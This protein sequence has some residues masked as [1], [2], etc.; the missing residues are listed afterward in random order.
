MTHDDHQS[1][2]ADAAPPE[3]EA[4][5]IAREKSMVWTR[6]FYGRDV[7]DRIIETIDT[8]HVLQEN[9]LIRYLLRAVMAGVLVALMYAFAYQ[10]KTD[11]GADF[12]HGLSL[13]IT[14]ISFSVALALIYFTNSELLTSNFM[15]FTVGL[16]YRKVRVSE[17]LAVLGPCLL[18]NLLGILV[19]VLLIW[20]ADM[21]S[22]AFVDNVVHTVQAKTVESSAWTIFVKAIFANY[23]I[24]ISVI[25]AMQVRES[26]AKIVVFVIGVTVFAYMGYEHVIA[27]SALFVMALFFE[28]ESVSTLHIG[29]NFICSLL[30]N[31][32]GG[33]LVVGLFY[34]YLNDDRDSNRAAP[35]LRSVSG[36]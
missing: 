27:N 22:Q 13:Y 15:Y 24:N 3:T 23:F 12:N 34:A 36:A 5:K 19:I 18:G 21:M 10:V 7:M 14:A 20:S 17:T 29:K 8:K 32:V 26:M 2:A 16:Y 31:Y 4:E 30:G 28:P 25:I 11:L 1:P 9:F 6:I 33:G 35:G